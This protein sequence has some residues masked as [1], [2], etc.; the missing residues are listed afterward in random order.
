MPGGPNSLFIG[1]HFSVARLRVEPQ[2]GAR[3]NRTVD[4]FVAGQSTLGQ[5]ASTSFNTNAHK[6]FGIK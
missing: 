5:S 3:L 1:P 4:D 2:G 6:C